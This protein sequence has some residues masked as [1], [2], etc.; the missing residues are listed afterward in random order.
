MENENPAAAPQTQLRAGSELLP[1]LRRFIWRFFWLCLSLIV[2]PPI[3]LLSLF[4]LIQIEPIQEQIIALTQTLLQEKGVILK[5][6][7]LHGIVPINFSLESLTLADK[8]GEWLEIHGAHFNWRPRELFSGKILIQKIG[9]RSLF[10]KRLPDRKNKSERTESELDF[11][12]SFPTIIIE[13]IAFPSIILAK[14]FFEE[15]INFSI[16]GIVTADKIDGVQANFQLQRLDQKNTHLRLTAHFDP[17]RF[18]DLNLNAIEGGGLIKRISKLPL[19]GAVDL[20]FQGHGP[21]NQWPGELSL[22]LP[23]VLELT[24]SIK[25]S[26]EKNPQIHLAGVVLPKGTWLKPKLSK[27]LG[28]NPSFLIDIQPT[29][30]RLTLRQLQFTTPAA[31]LTAHGELN[32]KDKQIPVLDVALEINDLNKIQEKL[33]GTTR[34]KITATGEL[35][36]PNLNATLTGQEI[37]MGKIRVNQIITHV[38]ANFLAPIKSAFPGI[39]LVFDGEMNGLTALN[40]VN[41]QGTLKVPKKDYLEIANFELTTGNAR[42]SLNGTVNPQTKIGDFTLNA[43]IPDLAPWH[44]LTRRQLYGGI[45][46]HSQISGG[47]NAINTQIKI[48]SQGLQGLPSLV[49]KLIGSKLQLQAT[50]RIQEQ[51]NIILDDL[52]FTGRALNFN[53]QG[54]IPINEGTLGLRTSLTLPKLELLAKDASGIVNAELNLKGELPNLRAEVIIHGQKIN[55]AQRNFRSL[56][57]NI[58]AISLLDNPHGD[59][60]LQ[61]GIPAQMLELRAN[62]ERYKSQLTVKNISLTAPATAISGFFNLDLDNLMLNGNLNGRVADLGAIYPWTSVPNLQGATEFKLALTNSQQKQKM[63]F[64]ANGKKLGSNL[65]RIESFTADLESTDLKNCAGIDAR[66]TT[67]G[68]RR[69]EQYLDSVEITAM[70]NIQQLDSNMKITAPDLYLALG[71]QFGLT[72]TARRIELNTLNGKWHKKSLRLIMPAKFVSDIK[73]IRISPVEL[74]FGGA[75]FIAE[76][77]LNQQSITANVTLDP[78]PLRLLADLGIADLTGTGKAILQLSGAARAPS[79]QLDIEAHDVQ[80]INQTIN[81]LPP[82]Q[83]VAHANLNNGELATEINVNGI[84]EIPA[85]LRFSMPLNVSIMPFSFGLPRRV[86]I[87]GNI[88]GTVNIAHLNKFFALDEHVIAGKMR[89]EITLGGTLDVPE[90]GGNLIIENGRYENAQIGTILRDIN[91]NLQFAGQK[92][93]LTSLSATDGKKG[94]IQGVGTALLDLINKNIQIDTRL[95]LDKM[96]V[97]RS[98]MASAILN[99]YLTLTGN[100]QNANASGKLTVIKSELN[101]PER[102]TPNVPKLSVREIPD[103]AVK[104]IA[105]PSNKESSYPV[106]VDIFV[107]IPAQTFVRGR[108]LDSEW[109]GNLAINGLATA[110]RITGQLYIQRGI[111]DFLDRR[112]K[113]QEGILDFHGGYPPIPNLALKTEATGR[114]ITAILSLTGAATQPKLTLESQPP[115]PQDEVLARLLFDRESKEISGLQ[116]IKLATALRTLTGGNGTLGIDLLSKTRTT[117]G[118]DKLDMENTSDAENSLKAGKYLR[119]NVY[120]EVESGL[121]TGSSAVR[122]EKEISRK[123]S[124]ETSVD[125]NSNSAFG[126][127]WKIDY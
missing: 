23:G 5:L 106:N 41:W 84:T 8:D 57:A 80:M 117:L 113:I 107:E 43:T 50:A 100:S 30:H 20:R 122:V 103:R 83:I 2:A 53:S 16:N 34:L 68:L 114:D 123:L 65:G 77:T 6:N 29:K 111:F 26:L 98:D 76:G 71:V 70:G 78:I 19:T 31:R 92:L 40:K 10:L 118:L 120:L 21:I 89:S 109:R 90:M 32:L 73:G 60:S 110:P 124:V 121:A 28:K 17:R 97:M 108:G 62:L 82:T 1:P 126:I 45:S 104:K 75:A 38:R 9:L 91:L 46:L 56:E 49:E 105:P 96:I 11:P 127:N 24:T 52:N 15:E 72:P 25:T 13:K 47:P 36:R 35:A 3:F 95:D 39:N 81:S 102:V 7:G 63:A 94:R 44:N 67:T 59:F 48:D 22:N 85:R 55:Y 93:T 18:L 51:R 54:N 88:D 33:F 87:T 69:G 66:I 27:L 74:N 119:G 61:L 86:P 125:H 14:N 116:A 37:A 42:A 101:I 112:F 99:G 4:A 115:F 12:R 79:M 58:N 64:H